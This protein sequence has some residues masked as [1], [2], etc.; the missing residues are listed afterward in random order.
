MKRLRVPKPEPPPREKRERTGTR[1]PVTPQKTHLEASLS[2][3]TRFH[4]KLTLDRM[5]R[6]A[7]TAGPYRFCVMGVL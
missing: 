7:G 1:R 3:A 2:P 6:R 4:D 5:D